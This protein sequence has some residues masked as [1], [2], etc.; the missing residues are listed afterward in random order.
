MPITPAEY[1]LALLANFTDVQPG[2]TIALG[3][4]ARF[5]VLE[6]GLALEIQ[7][8]A[9]DWIEQVRWTET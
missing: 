7:D 8:S 9:G 2:E 4:K 6:D 1:N 5:M 3:Q